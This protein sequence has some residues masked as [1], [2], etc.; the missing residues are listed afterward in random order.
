MESTTNNVQKGTLTL[1]VTVAR[2]L[3]WTQNDL[4]YFKIN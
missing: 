2:F 4:H 1:V 3:M